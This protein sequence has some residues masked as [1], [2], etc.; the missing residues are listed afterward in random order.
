MVTIVDFVSE[1]VDYATFFAVARLTFNWMAQQRNMI[2]GFPNKF[3]SVRSDVGAIQINLTRYF[4]FL[5][6]HDL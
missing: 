5:I 3:G 6:G 4:K 1:R 2:Q